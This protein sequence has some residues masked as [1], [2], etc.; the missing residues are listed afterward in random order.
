M[1]VSSQLRFQ[2]SDDPLT[3][4]YSLHGIIGYYL[5]T[6][7]VCPNAKMELRDTVHT[8][9]S[10]RKNSPC[11]ICCE[12]LTKSRSETTELNGALYVSPR[13]SPMNTSFI[14]S[15]VIFSRFSRAVHEMEQTSWLIAL[16]WYSK[17][18]VK[19]PLCFN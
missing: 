16:L 13:S 7:C 19:L 3:F 4:R 15:S 8:S 18:Q 14:E 17:V 5:H 10:L 9:Q 1:E 6:N 2:S 12:W 11:Y